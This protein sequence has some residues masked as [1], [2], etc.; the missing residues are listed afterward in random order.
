MWNIKEDIFLKDYINLYSG[1]M[2]SYSVGRGLGAKIINK[3]NPYHK[4]DEITEKN[5]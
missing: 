4:F 3:L 1:F 5:K 2:F